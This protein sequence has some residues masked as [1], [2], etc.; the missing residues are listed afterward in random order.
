M[1]TV[2]AAL[3]HGP[4]VCLFGSAEQDLRIFTVTGTARP[5]PGVS[6]PRNMQI[7]SYR[8]ELSLV[9]AVRL[10]E[11]GLLEL[12]KL[13]RVRHVIRIGHFHSRDDAFYVR[14]YGAHYWANPAHS[15]PVGVPLSCVLNKD[16]L[17]PFP[18]RVWEFSTL[19]K[20][21]EAALFVPRYQLLITCDSVHNMTDKQGHSWLAV[22]ASWAMGLGGPAAIGTGWIRANYHSAPGGRPLIEDFERLVS[23][24][25]F[26]NL[27]TAHGYPISDGTARKQLVASV[28]SFARRGL[29]TGY[30]PQGWSLQG[31]FWCLLWLLDVVLILYYV[32][33]RGLD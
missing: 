24:V 23:E 30:A 1:D 29:M 28:A 12:D 10:D 33:L 19:S 5:A 17:L 20:T 8:H 7:V 25:P 27:L 21:Y 13:G 15:L 22:I 31:L 14:R 2:P 32:Y 9:S 4:I 11:A 18:A 6:I 3:P 16:A 26:A